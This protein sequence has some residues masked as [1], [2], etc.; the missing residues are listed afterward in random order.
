MQGGAK[1]NKKPAPGDHE[2]EL[3][4]LQRRFTALSEQKRTAEG[5]LLTK[6]IDM[7]S[8]DAHGRSRGQ[9]TDVGAVTEIPKL[10]DQIVDLRRKH[11][12]LHDSNHRKRHDLN[13]L[14]DKLK[15]LHSTKYK[16]TE[17]PQDRLRGS[18]VRLAECAAR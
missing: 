8:E 18:E 16:P 14:A 2:E 7:G 11:D 17:T 3:A 12:R 10:D 6:N 9:A 15:D 5:T 4:E 1:A 13:K